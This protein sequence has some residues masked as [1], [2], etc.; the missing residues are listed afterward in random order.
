MKTAAAIAV[1]F[2]VGFV[3]GQEPADCPGGDAPVG[4]RST[5]DRYQCSYGACF[6]VGHSDG[7]RPPRRCVHS[8]LFC[9]NEEV[10]VTAIE[11][12]H[13]PDQEPCFCED[14][15]DY[16]ATIGMC[17]LGGGV[18]TPMVTQRA[19]CPDGRPL[20]QSSASFEKASF[21]QKG[22]PR[23]VIGPV[24][25]SCDMT[26]DVNQGQSLAIARGEFEGCNFPTREWVTGTISDDANF[27]PRAGA[28]ADQYLFVTGDIRA[29]NP[30]AT[31]ENTNIE[32]NL[33]LRGPFTAQD[34][35]ASNGRSVSDTVLYPTFSGFD[36]YETDP[37][38]YDDEIGLAVINKDTGVPI[39]VMHLGNNYHA[40]N[41][42]AIDAKRN[43]ATGNLEVV[44]GGKFTGTL[45]A[46]TDTCVDATN[47]LAS[48]VCQQTSGGFTTTLSVN[49][50]PDLDLDGL[51]D[52]SPAD[53]GGMT[54]F[55]MS[56][57]MQDEGSTSMLRGIKWLVR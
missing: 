47:A 3:C 29:N 42:W 17:D 25:T 45:S 4:S 24:Y 7:N 26:C 36:Y 9:S 28:I 18:I 43:S 20:C 34:P 46:E 33:I 56:L 48:T 19:D 12:H 51:P 23:G 41:S 16:P 22:D 15:L 40:E 10:F 30:E 54:T 8:S 52:D 57:D 14:I 5:R 50:N 11:L 21:Y 49:M 31:A 13:L 53:M 27:W 6:P 44:L 32:D 35:T 39:E 2:L 1:C 38:Q 37:R 55:V